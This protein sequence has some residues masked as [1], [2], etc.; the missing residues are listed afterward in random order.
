[1]KVS[2]IIPIIEITDYLRESIP[3]ILK[4]DHDDIEIIVIPNE[5]PTEKWLAPDMPDTSRG[6]QAK[7]KIIPNGNNNASE[8]RN[9]GVKNATGEIV[10]FLD[11]DAY[12]KKD[13]LKNALKHFKETPIGHSESHQ[14]EESHTKISSNRDSSPANEAGQNDNG[15]HNI[16]AV[17]GP[18]ITPESDNIFQKASAAAFESFI[19]GG[20][21]RNRYL[22]VG[23]NRDIDDWPSVNLLVR[24]DVFVK[25][26][27]FDK[28]Y[29]PG[30]DTKLCLE[31]LKYGKI[32]YEPNAI[33][34]H[35]RRGSLN[36]HLRQIGNYGLHRGHF[37]RLYPQNSLKLTYLIPSL[38]FL[39]ILLILIIGIL[40][41]F[42]TCLPARQVWGLGFGIYYLLAPLALYFIIMFFDIIIISVRYRNPLVG[43]ATIPYIFF[44]H[45]Y[46][47][48]RFIKGYFS[49]D[50][51][52]STHGKKSQ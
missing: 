33:V 7:I 22:P 49:R 34:H 3:E 46:Y 36:K 16:V 4:L 37:A 29:W 15:N 2:I 41:L 20:A 10:A 47:G 43:L 13:W 42:G 19:G 18:A 8:K 44:T 6:G 17:G 52:K 23:K 14:G 45:I 35:H 24:R 50:I 32:V 39:Y 48:L 40:N 38:F 27:G 9:I 5:M 1:M 51:S 30:E 21:T 12:P 11:D 26:G 28:R 31:L 25:T